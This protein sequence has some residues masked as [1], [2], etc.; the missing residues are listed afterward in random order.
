M[1]AAMARLWRQ[2]FEPRGQ[3]SATVSP[4]A[5]Q[6]RIPRSLLNSLRRSVMPCDRAEPL[7]LVHV[8]YVAEDRRTIAV[9]FD[10]TPMPDEAYV[11]GPDG[12]NFDARWLVSFADEQLDRNAGL[13]LAH[14]HGGYGRPHFGIVDWRTNRE[15]LAKLAV[16]VATAP[17]GAMLLSNDDQVAVFTIGSHLHEGTVVVVP[18]GFRAA[19]FRA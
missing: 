4:E 11:D 17:Y 10:M 13:L 7:S 6:L 5:R 14:S 9:A 18:D 8:R 3:P 16:G 12:A 15:I 2:L 19:D 1:I